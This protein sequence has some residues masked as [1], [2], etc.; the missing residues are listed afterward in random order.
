MSNNYAE[1][2]TD[3][4]IANQD[5][6]SSIFYIRVHYTTKDGENHIV[7]LALNAFLSTI[8]QH[9]GTWQSLGMAFN[10]LAG[11]N[12]MQLSISYVVPKDSGYQDYL[13]KLVAD[14]ISKRQEGNLDEPD[15]EVHQQTD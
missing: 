8:T 3:I 4:I 14:I 5:A 9:K 7:N 15:K 11:L 12:C 2:D 6:S 10:P 13:S 1:F